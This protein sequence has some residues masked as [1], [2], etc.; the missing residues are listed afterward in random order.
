MATVGRIQPD[1]AVLSIGA[2]N[3]ITVADDGALL[4]TNT[5]WQGF[6]DDLSANGVV[7]ESASCLILGTGGSARAVAYAL[8]RMGAGS[9]TFASRN[10]D[11][12]PDVISYADI[13]V[14]DFLPH[15][16]VNCTPTGMHPHIEAL[17][18]SADTP[19]PAD[20]VLYDLVYN[21]AETAL[22]RQASAAGA[23]AIGGLGMLV[24]QGALSFD[25]WTGIEPPLAVMEEAARMK[26]ELSAGN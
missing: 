2:A 17:P 12:R 16:I 26:L 22:M 23:R 11:G 25:Q 18:W 20:A 4:A 19:F 24:Q 3:T 7:V 10:P 14:K 13:G 9:V 1:K 8:R 15:L 6:C 21:P 5:D